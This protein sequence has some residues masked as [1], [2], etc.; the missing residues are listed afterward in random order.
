MENNNNN[1]S[2]LVKSINQTNRRSL[3]ISVVHPN[4]DALI[5]IDDEEKFLYEKRQW[6]IT[7]QQVSLEKIQ[8]EYMERYKGEWNWDVFIEFFLYHQIFFTILGPFMVILFSVWPG[9]I[10]M[11]NMKFYGNS[12][13]FYTQILLWCGSVLGGLG[14]F[15]WDESIIT[16][17]E[18]LFLWY[19]LTIRSV[20]IAAK[21]A[22]FSKSVINLYK[23]VVLP[24]D[25][26]QFDLMMNDWREQSPKILFLEPYRALQRY[27]F[28]ISLFKMDFIVQPHQETKVAIDKVDISYFKDIGITLDNDE[29]SGFKLFGYLV[30]HYQNQNSANTHLYISLFEAF[31][32]STTPI[33]LRIG[34]LFN[35][36]EALDMF[37]IVLNLVSSFI[38]FWGSIIFFHQAFYDFNRKFFLLEQLLL[39]IKVRPDQ[40]EQL[41][42]LPTIN[43]NNITTWQAWSM[44]RAISFDYGQTYNFRTQGFYSL[45][46]LGF[47]VLIFLTLLL[48][49]DFVHLD[50]FQLILL[51]ELA[52][53]IFGFTTYY[54]YQ[55]AK[56][57]TYLDQCEVA[58]QDVKS[59][60]Q[61][62]L[63]MKDIYFE[64]KKEPQNYIH[65]KFKQLLQKETQIEEIIKSIIQELDDNIRIIQYDS[66]NNP[67][68][69]YGIKITFNLLKSAAVGLSTIYSYSLQ[70][71]FMQIK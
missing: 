56:L 71:R 10:L 29:Y 58:L 64:Q 12:M 59:I 45:C 37:R 65:K 36:V 68:K 51:S 9:M 44:M 55:G 42:L 8:K 1:I 23:N 31:I 49:L 14:Y 46:F 48:I 50:L 69:L 30:N 18:I 24:D 62:L 5:N 35:S 27:Q 52:I 41:K 57:N 20:V 2:S 53:M 43:F 22:T 15:L 17:T 13:A 33:W 32:L 21:Y 61:D 54:L 3:K 66:R 28:E 47:I 40:I 63:R 26:F 16:L 34:D 19:A 38:G 4:D 67:F 39:I 70:Q 60:Y 6:E 11:K 25:V 7:N